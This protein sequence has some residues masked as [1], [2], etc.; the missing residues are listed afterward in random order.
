MMTVFGFSKPPMHAELT[1]ENWPIEIGASADG[2]IGNQ[3][4]HGI[5]LLGGCGEENALRFE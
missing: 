2:R 5:I 3:F 1:F 4:D